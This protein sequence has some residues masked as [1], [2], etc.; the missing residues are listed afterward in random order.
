MQ[1]A[2][3]ERIEHL[4]RSGG[5]ELWRR[6][7]PTDLG[8]IKRKLKAKHGNFTRAAQNLGISYTHFA[9][10]LGGR[11]QVIWMVQ[12]IQEDLELSDAD[13]LRLWPLLRRW[14]R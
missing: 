9:H 5:A 2:S 8:A 1:A 12:R 4:A 14:P 10:V 3:A 13:V 7:E 11:L 6:I